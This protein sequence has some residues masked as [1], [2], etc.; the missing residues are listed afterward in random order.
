M[1][2]L[3]AARNLLS[4]LSSKPDSI[5]V[6]ECISVLSSLVDAL[7]SGLHQTDNAQSDTSP[8]VQDLKNRLRGK[9]MMSMHGTQKALALDQLEREHDQTKLIAFQAHVDESFARSFQE[10][11]I[12][13]GSNLS[14]VNVSNFKTG[15]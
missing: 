3:I 5:D 10:P 1:K 13:T 7:S 12:V 6:H 9:I 2:R 15:A 14:F 4:R 8:V 11:T